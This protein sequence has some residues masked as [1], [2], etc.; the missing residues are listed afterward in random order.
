M[1]INEVLENYI[2]IFNFNIRNEFEKMINV[3][4]I[5]VKKDNRYDIDNNLIIKYC[6]ENSN[7]VNE[8]K[9][10][11]TQKN[12]FDKS[13]IVYILDEFK[14]KQLK[15]EFIELKNLIPVLMP[16]NICLSR[17]YESA[18][19]TTALADI[20]VIDT[21]SLLQYLEK[22]DI[23]EMIFITTKLLDENN[24]SYKYLKTKNEKE[25]IILENSFILY[26][27]QNK[28]D[29][30]ISQMQKFIID[31]E[32]NNLG[33]CID[34]LFYSSNQKCIIEICDEYNREILQKV[35]EIA[36]NNIKNFIILN[37]GEDVA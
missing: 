21:I 4:V 3:E 29:D 27:S 9:I 19:F 23:D 1:S 30:E 33:D 16:K 36:K 26:E 7:Y 5:S 14:I 31:I 11:F 20:L 15:K 18:P 17:V 22:N 32:K 10:E 24:I 25:K 37:N 6:D 13:S 12:D 34:M 28:K 35:E 8:F 2:K